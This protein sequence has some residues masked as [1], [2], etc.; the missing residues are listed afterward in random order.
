MSAKNLKI[1]QLGNFF[2][3]ILTLTLNGL[4]NALPINNRATGEISDSIPNLF[5]PAGL[6]FAIWGV[7][8]LLL[9]IFSFYQLKSPTKDPAIADFL[10]RI[11]VWN[12]VGSVSNSLWILAWHYGEVG[13]SLVLMLVLLGSLLAI[14]RRLETGLP[15]AKT[16]TPL[17]KL[18]FEVPFSVYLGWITVATIAN[19]TALA[20]VEEW[21]RWGISE[22]TWTVL[23]LIVA[24]GIT[25]L[26][27]WRRKDI[28]YSLVVIWAFAGII[29]K[30][31]D[32]IWLP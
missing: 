20:V 22:A 26:M 11:G 12:I 6:T 17:Q 4:A 29:I 9:A 24:V 21:N 1:L 25:S 28:A 5:V 31:T 16:R 8:Y 3:F 32:P 15:A 19:V 14:Y 13:W 18:A 27:L 23:V 10:T 30:R 2:G 7:I